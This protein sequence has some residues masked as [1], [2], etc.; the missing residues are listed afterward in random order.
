MRAFDSSLRRRSFSSAL[1]VPNLIVAEAFIRNRQLRTGLTAKLGAALLLSGVTVLLTVGTLFHGLSLGS[2]HHDENARL[3]VLSDF[4][5]HRR[6]TL[7]ACCR[8]S[9]EVREGKALVVYHP[10]V[11]AVWHPVQMLCRT[12]M[13]S[14]RRATRAKAIGTIRNSEDR[15]FARRNLVTRP[16]GRPT[17]ITTLK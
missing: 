2:G 8:A 5:D 11:T 13:D 10:P 1:Y 7:R 9:S 6:Q 15:H 16:G 3:I 12:A 14:A 17:L 4:G